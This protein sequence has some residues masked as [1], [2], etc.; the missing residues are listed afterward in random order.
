MK[1]VTALL[2]VMGGSFMGID[3]PAPIPGKAK[4]PRPLATFV[5]KR[6]QETLGERHVVAWLGQSRCHC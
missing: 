1:S 6:L 5:A 3:L 4:T 2:L